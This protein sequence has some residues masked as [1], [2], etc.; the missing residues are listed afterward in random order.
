MMRERG[1]RGREDGSAGGVVRTSV[2]FRNIRTP[3][4]S[5]REAHASKTSLGVCDMRHAWIWAKTR[6]G[7]GAKSQARALETDVGFNTR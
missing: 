2:I 7:S 3:S 1:G 5:L 6:D 4:W